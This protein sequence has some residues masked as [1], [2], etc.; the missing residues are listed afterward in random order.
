VT[1][2]VDTCRTVPCRHAPGPV[3]TSIAKH[4]NCRRQQLHSMCAPSPPDEADEPAGLVKLWCHTQQRLKMRPTNSQ[5]GPISQSAAPT[6]S[7]L[8]QYPNTASLRPKAGIS[9]KPAATYKSQRCE[10]HAQLAQCSSPTRH[11]C[12]THIY[13]YHHT[14]TARATMSSRF[15]LLLSRSFCSAAA[16]TST[17]TTRHHHAAWPPTSNRLMACSCLAPS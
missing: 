12:S 9:R 2:L 5:H 17:S 10:Q 13:I 11:P 15:G 8:S 1:Q 4:N 3:N 7:L 14:A 6:L 16:H